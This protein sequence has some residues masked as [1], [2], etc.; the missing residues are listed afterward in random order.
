MSETT[1]HMDPGFVSWKDDFTG[2]DVRKFLRDSQFDDHW[3]YDGVCGDGDIFL[4]TKEAAFALANSEE[5]VKI[6]EAFK[7]KS[8]VVEPYEGKLLVTLSWNA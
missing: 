3:E 1:I 4:V 7:A 8:L 6:K 2:D 5:L